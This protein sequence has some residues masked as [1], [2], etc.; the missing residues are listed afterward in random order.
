MNGKLYIMQFLML[1]FMVLMINS[2]K[3]T[4]QSHGDKDLRDGYYLMED[5]LFT[6]IVYNDSPKYRFTG[7]VVIPF[8]VINYME[9]NN[10]ILAISLDDDN[11][12]KSYWIIDKSISIN[13]DECPENSSCDS[14]LKS[15]V[16][17]PMD[18]IN[19]YNTIA[20]KNI[21]LKRFEK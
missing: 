6:T 10:Y 15:N 1:T 18:S 14:L 11:I 7:F 16:Q 5:G 20:K 17:G 8:T 2:C 21:T 9:G 12:I 13:L 19:F 3:T 4:S